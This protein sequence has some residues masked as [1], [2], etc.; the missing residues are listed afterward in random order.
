MTAELPY[1]SA[2]PKPRR[3]RR[4]SR[5][6]AVFLL[7][8]L[9]SAPIALI[10]GVTW[11]D[12]ALHRGIIVSDYPERPSSGRGSTWLFIGSDSRQELT[13]EQQETLSTGGDT[14]QGR[15]DTI[16]LVHVP[17]WGSRTPATMVSL[18]RDSQVPIP[19][20]SRMKINA[21]F[22]LGGAP[23]LAQTV[24]Q[25]TGLRVDHVIEMGFSGFAAL[26]DALGGIT[27]CPTTPVDDPLAGI[28]LPAGCQT[29]DGQH[30]LGY[31]RTRATPRADLDRMVNQRLVMSAL[32]HRGATPTTWL[33]P[34]RWYAVPRAVVD[35]VT[36]DRG[37][38]VWELARL[39]W[40]LNQSPTATTVPIGAL[41]DSD[42]GSVVIWNQDAA[43]Q[44]FAALADDVPVPAAA[45]DGTT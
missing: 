17:R 3:K 33:N 27:A 32:L 26:V 16:V 6:L 43:R 5:V 20:Q 7:V 14:G 18:P 12:T 2:V 31:V 38:H 44:L 25:A 1:V 22:A 40:A 24:E 42:A 15:A 36:V 37:V 30:A 39:A 10:G 29:L 8:V 13:T 34:W 4:W 19:G 11:L 45:L 23:L 9:A 35:A 28:N 21:A 41:T